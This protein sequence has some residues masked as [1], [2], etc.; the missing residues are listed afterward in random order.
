M[1]TSPFTIVRFVS[2][3]GAETP[4]AR[5]LSPGRARDEFALNMPF[6][7][8]FE[9]V[10]I[11]GVG[12]TAKVPTCPLNKSDGPVPAFRTLW[13]PIAWRPVLSGAVTHSSGPPVTVLNRHRPASMSWFELWPI[14]DREYGPQMLGPTRENGSGVGP[15]INV[16]RSVGAVDH[17]VCTRRFS[18]G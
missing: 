14:V 17:H 16:S 18:P 3:I 6:P 13:R 1:Y 11:Q 9:V 12:A 10:T 15:K 2:K 7:V 4:N 5:T 8:A